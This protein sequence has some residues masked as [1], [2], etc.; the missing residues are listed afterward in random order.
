MKA[1]LITSGIGL[2]A[3][4]AAADGG[5][6]ATSAAAN[7]GNGG[8]LLAVASG[9]RLHGSSSVERGLQAA[10]TSVPFS[11]G[12]VVTMVIGDGTNSNAD[13]SQPIFLNELSTNGSLMQ[14][15]PVATADGPGQYACAL[16]RGRDAPWDFDLDGIP[17]LSADGTV[18]T[19]VCYNMETGVYMPA[20]PSAL[21]RDKIVVVVHTD[22]SLSY[23]EPLTQTYVDFYSNDGIR[24][25]ATVDG[26]S[27]FWLSGMSY[28]FW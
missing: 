10:P 19:F 6:L 15:I 18:A 5:L 27:G 9:G 26:A 22:G 4:A 8:Q 13:I 11:C 12:S 1:A 17:S 28:D 3:S 16:G 25:V 21:E 24:Q 2:I 23:S 20:G 14:Q 7:G